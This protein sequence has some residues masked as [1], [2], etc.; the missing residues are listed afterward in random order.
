MC[1]SGLSAVW[2][3]C[4]RLIIAEGWYPGFITY[5]LYDL[6]QMTNLFRV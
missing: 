5:Q 6:E 1:G 4:K 2:E 3:H